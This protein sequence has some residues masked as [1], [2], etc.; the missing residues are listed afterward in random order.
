LS[1]ILTWDGTVEKEDNEMPT[2]TL[3]TLEHV[4]ELGEGEAGSIP[5]RFPKD[6]RKSFDV[7]LATADRA[8]GTVELALE[9]FSRGYDMQ[10]L[11]A[12]AEGA[13]WIP[14][15]PG[16]D[17]DVRVTLDLAAGDRFS[18]VSDDQF[19]HSLSLADAVWQQDRLRLTFCEES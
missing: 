10:Y 8:A 3:R 7:R 19:S 18:V 16:E 11:T 2:F 15:L 14:L 5:F 4:L 17:G 13:P 9:D 6:V 12:G 1:S